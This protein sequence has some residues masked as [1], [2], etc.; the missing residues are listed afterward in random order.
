MTKA[1]SNNTN[2]GSNININN[3]NSTILNQ[4]TKLVLFVI[5]GLRLDALQYYKDNIH[6]N[7]NHNNNED[8]PINQFTYIHRLLFE[9]ASQTQL[10]GFRADPPTTTS[11]RLKSIITGTFPNYVEITGNIHNGNGRGSSG[12]SSSGSNNTNTN[13]TNDIISNLKFHNNKRITFMGDDTWLT[14]LPEEVFSSCHAFE[15]FN[16]KVSRPVHIA[17]GVVYVVVVGVAVLIL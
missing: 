6:H 16:T 17:M 10:F 1:I 5:D 13:D 11:Q 12:G 2:T 14:L 8:Q 9:N 3:F 7:T 15:S 4:D